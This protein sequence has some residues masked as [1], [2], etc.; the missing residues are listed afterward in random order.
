M[1]MKFK[2]LLGFGLAI[3]AFLYGCNSDDNNAEEVVIV[4]AEENSDPGIDY[5]EEGKKI[6]EQSQGAL[7]KN[8]MNAIKAGGTEYAVEF[9]NIEAIPIT[10]SMA[11]LLG[12]SVQRVTDK[13]RNPDNLAN[14]A[15]MEHLKYLKDEM[16]NGN[17]AKPKVVEINGKMVGYY[18]IVTNEMCIKC[19]GDKGVTIE[20]ATFAKIAKLYPAD[21]ALGYKV[22]E[23]RGMWVVKF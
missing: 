12:A 15:E 2:V 23:L 3:G 10:D 14:E 20:P 6:A 18:A 11:T 1:K 9:C 13:P 4:N 22:N 16:A 19:H 8:L 21:K 7:G 5:L 17:S